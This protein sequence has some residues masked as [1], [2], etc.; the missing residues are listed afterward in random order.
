MD[1][2]SDGKTCG[3]SNVKKLLVVFQMKT[4]YFDIAIKIDKLLLDG[5]TNWQ[6]SSAW[7]KGGNIR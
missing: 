3:N 2:C 7:P 5:L 1:L 6:S 4:R